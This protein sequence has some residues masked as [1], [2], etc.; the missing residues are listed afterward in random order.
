MT[1]EPGTTPRRAVLVMGIT[2]VAAGALAGCQV[3]GDSNPPPPPP[4]PP[5][6]TEGDGGGDDGGGGTPVAS[7]GDV[8]VGGGLI[9]ADQSLVITQPEEGTF[10][11]FSAICTHQGCVVSSVSDGTINCNC[12]GSR[13][14][15]VDGSIVQPASGVA[16]D[17][18]DPLPEAGITV[19]GDTIELG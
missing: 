10:K 18:Q 12:H 3:Y 6:A 19:N 2:G 7:T 16:A 15:I 13:F 5:A 1:G 8:A 9:L 11:G 14:S 17:E 4:P